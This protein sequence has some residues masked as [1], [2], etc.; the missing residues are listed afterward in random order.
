[1][2][3]I[4]KDITMNGYYICFGTTS[5]GVLKK[6]TMQSRELS[7]ICNTDILNVKIKKRSALTK[8]VSL[9]PWAPIGF[10]Y[11]DLFAQIIDPM[12]LYIRRVT[13]DSD[14]IKFLKRIRL[15]YP[16]CKIVVECY[17]YP[18]DKDDFNRNVKFFVENLPHYLKDLI[19]RKKYKG[20]IDRFVTYSDD[21]YIFEVPTIQT[22]NGVDVDRE[23]AAERS[24]DDTID[25]ISVAH[26]QVHHA[27]ERII[28]GL[29]EYYENGGKEKIKIHMV[30]EGPEKSKYERLVNQYG[31]Q[32][33]VIFYGRKTGNELDEIY[34]K[35]DIA[36]A[37]F[38]L[39]KYDIKIISTLKMC[40]YL[41]KGLPVLSGCRTSMLAP[42]TPDF[43]LEFSNDAT[44]IDMNRV[45][46][47]YKE[48]CQTDTKKLTEKIRGF[49]KQYMDISV[50]MKPVLDFINEG[51]CE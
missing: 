21:E 35:A 5:T 38:G 24:V 39:Y 8:V 33:H 27:Y 13:S 41:A 20:C 9:L 26:M 44:P 12:F 6:I 46:D 31:L 45:I 17:T 50:V 28:E 30:G 15:K 19:Y 37:S 4:K 1:M 51:K 47:F 34:K 18:Y 48:F 22:A 23:I 29:K 42:Y 16:S 25:L 36:L 49:A 10:D 40:E 14:L 43:I 2:L 32:D 7:K 3:I 11:D